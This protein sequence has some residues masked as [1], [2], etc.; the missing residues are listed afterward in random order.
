[1]QLITLV[2]F[3]ALRYS[4]I[5]KETEVDLRRQDFVERSNLLQADIANERFVVEAWQE[6]IQNYLQLK[7]LTEKLSLCLS[8]SD[9]SS[10]ITSQINPFFGRGDNTAILYLFD[11]YAKELALSSSHKGQMQINIK[12]KKGDAYDQWVFKTLQ[13]LLIEDIRSDFRFDGEKFIDE[14]QRRIQSLISAPLMIENKPIG[15]LR[16][17]NPEHNY[18]HTEDLR[19]LNTIGHL[20]A[21][22]L[23]NAQL[24]ERVEELAI[25]DSLTGL[26]LRRYFLQRLGEE[27][28]RQLRRKK[29]LSFLMIDLDEFKLYNDKYGHMAGDIVLKTIGLILQENFQNPGHLV[30]RYGGEEFAVLLPDCSK[31]EA[32]AMAEDLR[33]K[34]SKQEIILRKQKTHITVSIGVASFPDDAQIKEEVIHK[35]DQAMYSAKSQGRNKVCTL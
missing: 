9:T 7:D 2:Y 24:Y 20:G 16:I 17:D 23:E 27:T 26:Y 11:V 30:C 10:T 15:I 19:L 22:A 18:F 13:P 33:K 34:I 28:S 5:E 31:P 32:M 1:M 3:F 4:M 35:A 12:Q 14:E 8:L 6:K 29:P 25:K 21:V